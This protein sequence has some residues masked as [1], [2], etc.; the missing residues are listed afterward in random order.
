MRRAVPLDALVLDRAAAEPLHRQLYKALRA[1]IQDDILRAGSELPSTR[2][3]ASD[4]GIARNT[5]IMAYDQLLAEGYLLT[6]A[7]ARPVVVALPGRPERASR[8]RPRASTHRLSRRGEL[9]MTQ[10]DH[11]GTPGHVAFHP[12]M[13]DAGNF[14][15]G[16]WSR[17][18]ARRANFAGETLFGTYHVG[19][20][21]ALREALASY[22]RT[23][24]G[25][26]C[27]AAQVVVTTG[28]Q[29][30]FDLLARLLLDPG[31]RVWMEEPGYFCARSAFVAAGAQLVA[32]PVDLHGWRLDPPPTPTARLIFVTPACQ[33]PLGVTMR[34]DQRLRL[35]QIADESDA[36]VI[37]DD[38]DGEYRFQ[39]GPIP[40][41][42]GIDRSER[43]IYVGTF[44]KILF[45][46]LRVGFMVLP[47][48]LVDRIP[49]ALSVTGQFAPL[50][51]QAAL[52]DFM[53]DGFMGHHLKRMRRIYAVRRERF[54][55]LCER[56]LSGRL[57]LLQGEVGIQI[58]GLLAEGYDDLKVSAHAH[59]LGVNV[60]PLSKHYYHG[61]PR[62]G[63]LLGYAAC[64]EQ[65][66][67][68]G[69]RKLAQAFDLSVFPAR[70]KKGP[71][72]SQAPAEPGP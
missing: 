4:L 10:P 51:L 62:H 35:L 60:S 27:T 45:P 55:D 63:L 29:A 19:G 30:A 2:V 13:P 42:Q 3:L 53:N 70:L 17:L 14:P 47:P 23:A 71:S 58:A 31:D 24:R 39:G 68:Q 56:H 33:H 9:M 25:V 64:D 38:F 57:T 8:K 12:G 32:L 65:Q 16:V 6:R 11:H 40:A 1:L 54:Y 18:L 43:V 26:H 61:A 7:G 37:E 15:F 59:G 44:A 28:A 66:M 67:E 34:M 36:W 22:L 46:A 41:M 49:H 72:P 5:I 69:I 21:P 50:L 48:L 20:L 52:A